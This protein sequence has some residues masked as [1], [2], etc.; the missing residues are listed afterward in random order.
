MPAW[1]SPRVRLGVMASGT[2]VIVCALLLTPGSSDSDPPPG[3]GATPTIE[4]PRATPSPTSRTR[5]HALPQAVVTALALTPSES[6]PSES[7][8]SESSTSES[9]TGALPGLAASTQLDL[10]N[11]ETWTGLQETPDVFGEFVLG[12]RGIRLDWPGCADC[13]TPGPT[14]MVPWGGVGSPGGGGGTGR[15]GDGAGGSP[16]LSEVPPPG[17]LTQSGNPSPSPPWGGDPTPDPHDGDRPDPEPPGV[18]PVR[19][20]STVTLIATL[21]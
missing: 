4:P 9:T 1:L 6:S 8:P 14:N 2:V 16:A 13:A 18:V 21:F 5:V 11:P 7:S 20:P 15:E 10:A 17:D 12:D 19:E 3:S